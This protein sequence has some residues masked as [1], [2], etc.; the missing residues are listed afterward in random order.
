MLAAGCLGGEPVARSALRVAER[1]YLDCARTRREEVASSGSTTQATR[2][3]L[4]PNPPA[5]WPPWRFAPPA[6]GR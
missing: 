2:R 1:P 5:V 3:A 4:V 6:P